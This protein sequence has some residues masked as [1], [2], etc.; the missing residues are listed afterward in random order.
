M[1]L[2]DVQNLKLNLVKEVLQ[3]HMKKYGY[4]PMTFALGGKN[5]SF[6]LKRYNS[7]HRDEYT[8]ILRE[9]DI[10][11]VVKDYDDVP[12]TLDEIWNLIKSEYKHLRV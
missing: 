10:P 6:A 3:Q 7:C 5:F 12:P 11:F 2:T 8:L 4:T 9:D 1:K